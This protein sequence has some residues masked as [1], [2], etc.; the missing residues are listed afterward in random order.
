MRAVLSIGSNM[1]DRWAL[2]RTV[3]DAFAAEIAAESSVYATPPW[4]VTD[5]GE[6]LNAVLIVEVAETPLNLLRRGQEL[7][8]AAER[9]RERHWGPRTLDVDLVQL[10]RADGSEITSTDPELTLPHPHAHDRA[11]VLIPWLEAD[12]EAVLDGRRVAEIAAGFSAEETAGVRVVGTFT[13]GG[14]RQ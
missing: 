12:P 6:F 10:I 8:D 5:Q 9:V 3:H 4:G 13:D 2:L 11:F 7:E 14:G 1:A